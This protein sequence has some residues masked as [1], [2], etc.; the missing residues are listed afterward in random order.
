MSSMTKDISNL[1][2]EEKRALV[3]ELLKQKAARKS[4]PLSFAQERLWFLDQFEPGSPIYNIPA[5]FRL[6]GPL[7]VRALEQSI[8]E[9]VNR[10][11]ILRTTFQ[12]QDGQ[13][14]QVISPTLVIEV[15]LIDLSGFPDT[16]RDAEAQ[17][18]T[19]NEAMAP[20]D[21]AQGPLLRTSLLKLADMDHL[22]LF[23]M[24]HIVSDAWSMGILWRELG[25]LYEQYS[26]GRKAALPRLP[27]QY[28][29]FAQWQRGYLTGD[30]MEQHL[31]YW[32]EQLANAPGVVELP[33][34]RPRP[35]V[36]S[37]RGA[38]ESWALPPAL[39]EGLKNLSQRTGVTLFMTLLT[40]FKILLYRYTS[41]PDLVVGT[42]I[43][44]RTRTEVEG[45]IGLFVNTL[46]LRTD[47]SGDP[48][49]LEAL[50]RVREVTLGAYAHQDLPFERLV[51]EQQPERNLSHNPLFQ[52]MFVFQNVPTT[53]QTTTPQQLPVPIGTG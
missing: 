35:A 16:V 45:L 3:G 49:F 11:E 52:L 14:V 51:E 37:F 22:L 7:N 29:D 47:L 44:N 12:S 21:L 18:L 50:N 41:R 17:R 15:P 40:A 5:A 53:P 4:M 28:A 10:H 42:P 30:V 8:N 20:F 13:P 19:A 23:T 31:K 39:A 46:V 27:I 38:M 26:T 34:D 33:A 43:A 9:I 2:L 48:S 1:S 32:R 25:T 6:P 36:Q 24:H